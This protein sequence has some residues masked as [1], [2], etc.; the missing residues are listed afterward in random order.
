[1]ELEGDPES[2]DRIAARLG[3]DRQSYILESYRELHEAEAARQGREPG[4]LVFEDA[5][6]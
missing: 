4:D 3:L 2:I 6:T 5:A 1:V